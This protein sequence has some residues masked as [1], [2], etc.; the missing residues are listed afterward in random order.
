MANAYIGQGIAS[1]AARVQDYIIQKP[2][3]DARRAEAL[4]RQKESE[5]R[6]QE[7]QDN[8]PLRGAQND[9]ALE[10]AKTELRGLQTNNLQESTFGAFTRYEGD[11]DA[12]HLNNFLSKAKQNPIGNNL[13]S[14][15]SRW[16][17]V[18]DTEE[19]RAML[20][21][22]GIKDPEAFFAAP[23]DERPYNFVLG[24]HADGKQQLLDMDKIYAASGFTTQMQ[25]NNLETLQRRKLYQQLEQAGVPYSQMAQTERLAH[26]IA[27]EENLPLSEAYKLVTTQGST[28]RGSMLERTAQKLMEENPE[29]SWMDAMEKARDLTSRAQGSELE[30]ET[31]R[32]MEEQGI[33]YDEAQPIAKKNLEKPT[34]AQKDL[35]AADAVRDQLDE[36]A[37][38]DFFSADLND[39]TT[40]RKMGRR[41]SELEKLTGQ[42]LTTEDKR[43]AREVRELTQ[44]GGDAGEA[45]TPEATGI[46]DNWLGNVKKYVSDNVDNVEAKASYETFR[47]TLRNALYGA[48]LTDG[49]IKAFNAA[50]GSLGQQAG[51]VLAQLRTQMGQLRTRLQ[52][53]YD[54]NDE[55]VA[56]Y[57][58]GTS[59]DDM[60]KALSEMD[61]RIDL[62]SGRG[63]PQ[64]AITPDNAIDIQDR[65][66]AMDELF[67]DLEL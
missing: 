60:D 5:L 33:S 66:K 53:I 25:K 65:K 50:V 55:Y 24:T 52:S 32:V 3:R 1:G 34:S 49:E 48:T 20:K 14:T 7:Y 11:G 2:E 39:R 8:A 44:L 15:W 41:I 17:A 29:L 35:G 4:N 23:P 47:N 38:G 57:Y 22:A 63:T 18:P 54:F 59:L 64:A 37:G 40:R 28:N 31:E 16:D 58:L 36:M 26:T 61:K 42:S 67:G 10:Q 46:I 30:R 6:L 19:G 56:Q 12:R 27:K 45:L 9:L 51:P 62:M 21:Q 13:Y 43:L